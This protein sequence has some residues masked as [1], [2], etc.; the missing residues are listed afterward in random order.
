[1][2]HPSLRHTLKPLVALT[3][4]ASAPAWA[5]NGYFAHGYGTKSEGMAGV[6][7]A[8]PL[9]ALAG[10]TNPAGLT[11]VGSRLDLGAQLFRPQ[12][13]ASIVGNAFGPDQS[14]DGNGKSLFL[15]PG[16]GYNR[17]I[18]PDL[19]VGL[20]VF[21]NGGMNTDYK[22]ANPYAR[23]GATG[24]AGVNLEQLFISPTV[25]YKLNADHSL[26]LA[27]NLG[28]QRFRASGIGV[29]QGFSASPANV[30]DKGND[31]ATGIGVRIGYLG[32]LN[33]QVRV[34][35]TYQS[36]TRFGKFDKYQGLFA[37]QGGFDT[38]ANHG[39]GVAIQASRDL[40]VAADLQRI[41]YSGV[42]AVG[43]SV[44]ALLGGVPLGA[45]NG[46]GFGWRDVTVVKLGAQYQ[47]SPQLTLRSGVSRTQNPIP[48]NETL[49][50]ILAPGV[51]RTH[52]TLGGTWTLDKHNELSVAYLHALHKAVNGQG[53]IPR[54]NPPA[55]FGGGEA[56]IRLKEDAVGVSWGHRF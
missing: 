23:F 3:L 28:Y 16:F 49:L 33:E 52:L 8:L 35:A 43:N 7:I 36:K 13:S 5:T 11:E 51:V 12:R 42:P 39:V 29:F 40:T 37:N 54:G 56:N 45:T 44:A 19:A 55:G 27:L 50:N 24:R 22:D 32:K 4:L 25:A 20:A 6:G 17:Q 9:D 31:S 34:G 47:V 41:Q 2:N 48:A 30:S 26:G 14:F 15:I 21:G 18:R 1:M 46:P 38:P 53:S 10:A